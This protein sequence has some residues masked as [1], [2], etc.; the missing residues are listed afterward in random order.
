MAEGT[1]VDVTIGDGP[2]TQ[3][4]ISDRLDAFVR[5][6]EANGD[7]PR[8]ADFVP[9]NPPAVRRIALV[10]LIKLDLD[11][12]WSQGHLKQ[13]EAYAAEFPELAGPA[14][15]PCDLI[16]AEYEA[17]RKHMTAPAVE[18]YAARFPAQAETVARLLGSPG[19]VRVARAKAGNPAEVL[20]GQQ[21]D[22]F[23]LLALVGEGAFAR[24]FLA[25]QRSMQRLV[26]VKVSADQGAEPQ[27]LGQLDHPHI[28]RV[29]DQRVLPDRGLRLLYMPY[30]P[31][32]TL[33]NVVPLVRATPVAER[34][35]KLLLKAVDAALTLRGEVPPAESPERARIAAMSWPETV[36]WLGARL[37]DA[38]DYA[39]EHGVLHRDLKPAN[40][41]LGADCAPRLADSNVS[42]S[43]KVDGAGPEA[44]FGGSLP[45]MSPE[46]AEAFNPAHSRPVDSLD[47]RADVYSLAVTLWEILTGSRPFPDEPVTGDWPK[48]LAAVAAHRLAG[49][50]VAALAKLPP[51]VLPGLT[52]VLFR[53]LEPDP[54]RRYA[55]AGELAGQLDLCRKPR[56]RDLIVPAPGWRTWVSHHALVA[57]LTIGLAVNGL[58]SWLNIVYN[59]ATLVDPNPAIR[60]TFQFLMII[61]NGTFFPACTALIVWYVW[62]VDRALKRSPPMSLP[63]ADL[64]RLRRR[65]LGIGN[66]SV[67]ITF[68]AWAL[69]G[70]IFPMAM[71]L[72][73]QGL[74]ASFHAHFL[75]SQ[76]LCGLVAVTYPQ[77]GITFLAVRCLFP[78]LVPHAAVSADDV[79]RLRAVDRAQSVY[80]LV[81]AAVP[82]LAVGLLAGFGAENRAVLAVLSVVGVAGFVAATLLTSA[83]R[84][85][86]A[87]LEELRA[88]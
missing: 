8:L 20:P 43:S 60:D 65:C 48:T 40:V 72:A 88:D 18:D 3:N 51:D 59:R 56:A 53:C 35:G 9:D 70:I 73:V 78:T 54:A 16:L 71:D 76:T 22:D 37:A 69:S 84:A 44:F 29:Y 66:V 82:M 79:A 63:A 55:T 25:R 38:L 52:D 85:D 67:L 86:R 11:F 62:P 13:V 28:V 2:A 77:F 24:V 30:L 46:Q 34:S 23:D 58:A 64:A 49:P 42:T 57:I 7:P 47:A 4:L 83:I 33:R 80:L 5:K 45:Y 39:H 15:V 14:G 10:E 50:D 26:A 12:R 27:T 36:A 75:A 19:T 21:L 87:A 68:A 1:A 61:V 74:P 31:G 41:L 81:A 6:W 32:G 17:R